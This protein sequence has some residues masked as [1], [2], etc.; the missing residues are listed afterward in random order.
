[1]FIR[2][3]LLLRE[4]RWGKDLGTCRRIWGM[5]FLGI[6]ASHDCSFIVEE[7]FD[8]NAN[9]TICHRPIRR[10]FRE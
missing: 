8:V 1:M 9:H 4:R 2:R 3:L 10:L 7:V 5:R 6:Q